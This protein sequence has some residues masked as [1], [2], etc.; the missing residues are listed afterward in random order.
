MR[1]SRTTA[2]RA[3]CALLWLLA[4]C[5]ARTQEDH[6]DDAWRWAG[7]TTE[8]GLP[9]NDVTS[10][11]E[12]ED[13]TV[14]AS[15][16]AGPAWFDGYQWHI[17]PGAPRQRLGI[18]YPFGRSRVVCNLEGVVYVVTRDSAAAL[19][20]RDVGLGAPYDSATLI[21]RMEKSLFFYSGGKL[22]AMQGP[23]D[24]V[25]GGI[26]ILWKTRSG[27]YIIRT[28]YG[29]YRWTEDHWSKQL[30]PV[31]GEVSVTAL[32]EDP[33]GGGL[34]AV[35]LPLETR[36][37]WEWSYGGAPVRNN[38]EM[39]Y[40]VRALDVNASGDA[41]VVY[42]SGDIRLRRKG[43]WTGLPSVQAR[44][45]EIEF[46]QWRANGDLWFGTERGLYLYKQSSSRWEVLAHPSPDGRNAVNELL[47]TRAGD[48]WV[49][50]A[51]GIDIYKASGATDHV[52]AVGGT[53]LYTVTGLGEDSDGNV[54]VSSG[55]TF[56]GAFRW[57]GKT[58]ER[59]RVS[60]D[61]QGARFHKIRRDRYGRLW[62]LGISRRYDYRGA[63]EVGAYLL[64][65]GKFT[66]WGEDEGLANGRVYSFAQTPDG[67]LWFGTLRGLSRWT[68]D[69]GHERA[70]SAAAGGRWTHWL[71]GTGLL[72]EKIFTLAADSAGRVWFGHANSGTGLGV[73][74]SADSVRYVM[75]SEGLANEFIW[76]LSV[77][78]AG[79]VWAAT[80]G[81]LCM[82]ANGAWLTYGE[83]SG[84][85]FPKLWPVLPLG[86]K[87][88]AGTRGKGVA[89]FDRGE[90]SWRQPRVVIDR[91]VVE[92]YDVHVRWKAYASWGDEPPEEIQ[93]RY[94]IDGAP[95]SAWSAAREI[96]ER[97]VAPGGH[98]V[99]VQA[100][101]LVGNFEEAGIASEFSV[102][103]P[104]YLR[105]IYYVPVGLLAFGVVALGTVLL[106]RKRKHDLE[107]RKSEAKFRAVA[108]MSP[109]AI[110]IYQDGPFLF[111]NPGAEALTGYDAS[112][113]LRMTLADLLH[114]D[115]RDLMRQREEERDAESSSVPDRAEFRIVTK[116]GTER[117]VDYRWGWIR[118]QGVPATLGTAFDITER[119]RAEEQL[120]TLT[121]ELTLTEERERHRMATYLHDVIGQTLA[122]C[123]IK[124]RGL[125]RSAPPEELTA[126]LNEVRELVDLSIRNTRSLTF[127]LCP[128]ILYELSFEAAVGWL[129]EE[130]HQQ[131]GILFEVTDDGQPKP[132]NE[133]MRTILFQALREIFVNVIKHAGARR[134]DVSIARDADHI[135]VVVHDDGAGFEMEKL[136]RPGTGGFGLFNIRERLKYLGGVMEITSSPGAGTR[137]AV[138]APL[139]RAGD[140]PTPPPR[141]AP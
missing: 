54:W 141:R 41:I 16:A 52:A 104:Y 126:P 106:A 12:T 50:T 65:E 87:V 26:D 100:R 66:R 30:W 111:A 14:W 94:R 117:W 5:A 84:L 55:A 28:Q 88:Y 57:D 46:V 10:L 137:V 76:D 36:G 123:R 61:P 69:P 31:A 25:N 77:D 33:S 124:I 2:F 35:L 112:A 80:D 108:Q 70:T 63:K 131:H 42:N 18:V 53:R 6:V 44:L 11:A 92:N 128:P 135:R 21:V 37:L 78:S 101:G 127:E 91:P 40:D 93:T 71:R 132:L 102:M 136:A 51:D 47:R 115:D 120:R 58:W 109:S 9:S 97:N 20:L 45:G 56:D 114:P 59:F 85:H 23:S 15:T 27:D 99:R 138:S 130:F 32:A 3:L 105:P 75:A 62:F 38:A 113:L 73:I 139:K 1:T 72:Y 118:F 140:A 7:F 110:V 79:A 19:P 48:L 34:A 43:R 4:P 86:P 60:D 67:A 134:A 82:Y 103:P 24:S 22:S 83:K 129:A 89:I 29:M 13:G 116:D 95:W 68:P 64:S 90:S 49:G 98:T 96:V 121:T 119:K 107:L 17:V 125:E 39:G 81:G 122:L 133:E 8:S 74:D